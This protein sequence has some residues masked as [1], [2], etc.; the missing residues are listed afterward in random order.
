[1]FQRQC[2]CSKYVYVSTNIS[3]EAHLAE[4]QFLL[5]QTLNIEKSDI[6]ILVTIKV[7]CILDYDFDYYLLLK[8][9]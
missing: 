1:M 4:G 3:S 7:Y 2:F 8:K 9:I 5:E 6:I